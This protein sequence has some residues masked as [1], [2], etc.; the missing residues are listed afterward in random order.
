MVQR[1]YQARRTS[2]P[3]QK[4]QSAESLQS[5]SHLKKR[6]VSSENH[7]RERI[8]HFLQWVCPSKGKRP[9]EPLQKC[10]STADTAQS[11]RTVKG[12]LITDSKAVET[13]VFMTAVGQILE[14]KMALHC[15]PHASELHWYKVEL[16]AP[17]GPPY[18]YHR[19]LSIKDKG[20]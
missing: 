20:E 8:K 14:K 13:Q 7:F 16:Q 9:E 12:R 15:G 1:F 19:L 6:Q 18:C 17:L 5:K 4:K 3:G 2:H 11:H 10:K